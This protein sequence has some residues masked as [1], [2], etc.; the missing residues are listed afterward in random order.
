MQTSAIALAVQVFLKLPKHTACKVLK[1][2]RVL[3]IGFLKQQEREPETKGRN[4]DREERP[5]TKIERLPEH[6]YA[7]LARLVRMPGRYIHR[8]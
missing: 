5:A 2:P 3:C 6:R 7:G 8:R 4:C 1:R